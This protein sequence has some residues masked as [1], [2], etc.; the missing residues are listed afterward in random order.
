MAQWSE[1]ALMCT[2]VQ[3]NV[4]QLSIIEIV[5]G[6]LCRASESCPLV[7][8]C[9]ERDLFQLSK[10]DAIGGGILLAA[11]PYLVSNLSGKSIKLSVIYINK[12]LYYVGADF[13]VR[14]E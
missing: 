3:Y 1:C 7:I 6:T 14:N 5:H 11:K 9:D 4:H 10:R 2:I 12:A 8:N 13:T